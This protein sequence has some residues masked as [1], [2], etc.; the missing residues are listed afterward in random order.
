MFSRYSQPR[1]RWDWRQFAAKLLGDVR[2][3]QLLDYGCGMGE[4]STYFALLGA[5]VS[6][7]DVSPLG[8]RLTRER[9]A[10]N[11][12]ADRVDAVE[13]D[14]TATSFPDDTFDLVHGLG[15]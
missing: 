14:A 2:G 12:V 10:H 4:E 7:I 3:R 15:I 11:G 13:M 5:T 1:H 6:A 8:I 9:A